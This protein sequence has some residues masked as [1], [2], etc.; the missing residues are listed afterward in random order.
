[1]ASTTTFGGSL[2]GSGVNGFSLWRDDK[3]MDVPDSDMVAPTP[4][5][6]ADMSICEERLKTFE[7]WPKFMR[8]SSL[9]LAKAGF[10]YTGMGDRVMC[11]SCKVLIKNWEPTDTAWGE[12]ARWRSSCNFV[13]MAYCKPK[14]VFRHNHRR[15]DT[16]DGPKPSTVGF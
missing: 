15:F 4:P 3:P 9:E 16:C 1:M 5:H 14:A 12:H 8:P 10:Y 7:E 11:F 13:K 6:V 2:N